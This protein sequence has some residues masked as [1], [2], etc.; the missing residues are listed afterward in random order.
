[1]NHYRTSAQFILLIP[2]K[3]SW[4]NVLYTLLSTQIFPRCFEFYPLKTKWATFTYV[5][6]YILL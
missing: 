4:R 5:T 6:Y 3:S 2:S 1:M